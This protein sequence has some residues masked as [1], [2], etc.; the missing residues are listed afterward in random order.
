MFAL[1]ILGIF[2]M[3]LLPGLLLI[4]LFPSRRSAIHNLVAVF[5]LSL[6]ANYVAVLV[7]TALKLYL[8]GVVFGIFVVELVL[9]W[10]LYRG[11]FA[12]PLGS[13]VADA[14]GALRK[15]VDGFSK[16][17]RDYWAMTRRVAEGKPKPGEDAGVLLAGALRLLFGALAVG[18]ILWMAVLTVRNFGT[19][20]NA[21]DAWASWDPWAVD[22]FYNKYAGN[23][24]GYPQAIPISWSI[25]YQFI[26]TESIKLFAKAIMP[27]FTLL[28]LLMLFDLG[29][30]QKSFGY[31]LGVVVTFLGIVRFLAPY[32]GEGYVDLPVAAITFAAVYS[33]L[34]AMQ[35]EDEATL[36]ETLVLGSLF[37]ATA[38]VVKQ[39][40]FYIM[41]FYPVLAYFLVLRPR[42]EKVRDKIT[43]LLK[44]LAL[45]LLI[46]VPWYVYTVIKIQQGNY[47]SNIQYVTND[48]YEGAT[49]AQRFA[50]ALSSLDTFILVYFFVIA[51]LLVMNRAQRWLTILVTLPYTALWA[52]YLSYEH[53]NL[54]IAF[55]LVGMAAGMGA[56]GLLERLNFERLRNWAAPLLVLAVLVGGSL[57]YTDAT[58]NRVQIDQQKAIFQ[59]QVNRRLYAYFENRGGPETV[60][61]DYPVGWLPGLREYW[62]IDRFMDYEAYR[63]RLQRNPDVGLLLI[64]S[65]AKPEIYQDVLGRIESGEY[66]V[67]FTVGEYMLLRIPLRE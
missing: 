53:R 16:G 11:W 48:I 56:Q 64:S 61:S 22:W 19:V 52:F 49:L 24:W 38:G 59:P 66:D 57:I 12:R 36:R 65:G 43:Q 23:T 10:R 45:G 39:P 7:L 33:L 8:R 9:L 26:G 44:P 40:G 67:Q 20:W 46:V 18:C 42:A 2:Q 41:A 17:A 15:G 29:L 14:A 13:L 3:I 32:I 30:R 55:P 21:W 4:R 50:S 54:A 31:F 51:A 27:L 63:E 1:G 35:T 58:I 25:S 62:V 28:T 60:I 34:V 37:S 47:S 5:T 6:L